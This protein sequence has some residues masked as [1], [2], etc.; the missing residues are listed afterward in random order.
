M[1]SLVCVSNWRRVA[2]GDKIAGAGGDKIAGVDA[3]ALGV[4]LKVAA[5]DSAELSKNNGA[6]ADDG[7]SVA[8]AD[9]SATT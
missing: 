2:G 9:A 8:P 1:T 5:T 3:T 4:R 6:G 7:I